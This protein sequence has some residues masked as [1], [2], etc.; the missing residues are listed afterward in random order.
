[1]QSKNS[2]GKYHIN[3]MV[4]K[5]SFKKELIELKNER[6]LDTDGSGRRAM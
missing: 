1:M 3:S 2:G 6:D 4:F 5:G